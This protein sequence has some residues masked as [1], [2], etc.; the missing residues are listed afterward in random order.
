METRDACQ[1]SRVSIPHDFGSH[2]QY[3]QLFRP[4]VKGIAGVF[5]DDAVQK[6]RVKR[7]M[8]LFRMEGGFL[9]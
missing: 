1:V 8:P 7:L 6:N 4:I 2:Y 9:L 3:D 5:P